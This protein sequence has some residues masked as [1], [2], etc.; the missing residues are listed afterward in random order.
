MHIDALSKIRKLY[1]GY[2][3]IARAMGISIPSAR[4][5]A[6]RYVKYKLI[7]RIKRGVYVLRSR[8]D[9]LTRAEEF[10]L[11]NIIQTPSYISLMT[12]LSYYEITTQVPRD[13]IES[14]ALNRSLG[15]GV[16]NKDFTYFKVNQELYSGFVRENNFFIA[17]PEKAFVDA[18]YLQ[19]LGYYDFDISSIDLSRMGK[20]KIADFAN[21]LPD[22]IKRNFK[23]HGYI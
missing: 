18:L 2:E 5:T 8:W 13:F 12:A 20:N 23:S 19:F 16:G 1:F 3:E 17:V 15:K 11:A 14:I 7:I 9:T 10:I 21:R 6:C 22:K 4:V